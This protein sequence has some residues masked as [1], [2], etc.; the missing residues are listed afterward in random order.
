MTTKLLSWRDGVRARFFVSKLRQFKAQTLRLPARAA[1]S[2]GQTGLAI[3]SVFKDEAPYL[4]EWILFHAMMGVRAFFLYD[5]GSI[6]TSAALLD[7]GEWGAEVKRLDWQSFD[8]IN[9]TQQLAHNHALANYGGQFRWMA[10]IDIDE[11][12]FPVNAADLSEVLETLTHLPGVSVPWV[13]FGPNGHAHQPDGL[14]IDN[15]TERAVFPPRQDQTSLLR[16]KT[17]VDP[18]AVESGGTHGFGYRG[19]GEVMINE[20]GDRRPPWDVRTPGFAT[21]ETLRLN[22]YF[23][24]S[25]AELAKKLKKGRVSRNGGVVEA[26][27]DR[28]LRQYALALEEDRTITRFAGAL[29]RRIAERR[30]R[31]GCGNAP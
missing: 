29:K 18:V 13:N 2:D 12:L 22:H 30:K 5:N 25:E 31:L 6:D 23:T 14:V 10:F 11:F 4:E 27:Y 8:G 1:A 19:E 16:Y 26:A 24:R 20:K 17:V 3:V 28:R 7:Q 9:A 21:S 15:Y